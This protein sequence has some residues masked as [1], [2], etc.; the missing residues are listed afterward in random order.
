MKFLRYTGA[1]LIALWLAGCATTGTPP[2]TTAPTAA[3]TPA[4]AVAAAAPAAKPLQPIIPGGP[5]QP[6]TAG[7]ASS[8]GVAAMTVPPD[9]WDR[10]RRG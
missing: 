5:L 6:M 3:D 7:Q 1:A 2:G 4:P 9:L 10:I 8:A